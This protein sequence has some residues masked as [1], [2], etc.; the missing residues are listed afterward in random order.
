MNVRLLLI[1]VLVTFNLAAKAQICSGNGNL[2]LYTNYDGGI[3]NINVDVNIPNL[4]IGICTYEPVQVNISGPFVNNVTQVL[5]AG[6]NSTQN[7]NNCNQ[8]NFITSIS[9]VPQNIIDIRTYPPV[10]LQNPNGAPNIICA[11]ACDTIGNQGGCNTVD[12]VVYYFTQQTGGTL[13]AHNIQYNCWLNTTYN[14]SAGGTCCIT[15]GGTQGP[16]PEAAFAS[17]T[18]TICAG[19]CVSYF[20]NSTDG[21]TFQWSFPGGNPSVATDIAPGNICYPTT[22]VYPVTLIA[23]NANGSDTITAANYVYVISPIIQPGFTYNQ[24]DNYTVEFT[25]TTSGANSYTWLFPDNATST[26]INPSFDFPSDG[27]YWVL[28]QAENICGNSVIDSV[29]ISVIKMGMNF[30]EEELTLK[31]IAVYPNPAQNILFIKAPVALNYSV[32]DIVGKQLLSGTTTG[33]QPIAINAL[34]KGLYIVRFTTGDKQA[35]VK[36]VKD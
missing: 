24:I 29:L 33:T 25:N 30:T 7:N 16:P 19:D 13:Y 27:D 36:F 23:T 14:V 26:D 9:G 10:D 35:V 20:N 15:P 17:N 22:G 4:K 12:Q 31:N 5:Y 3:I 28:L 11:Y 6:F 8:G 1:G 21:T 32:F 18:D 34:A 2:M